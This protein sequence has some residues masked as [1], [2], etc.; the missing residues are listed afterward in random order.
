MDLAETEDMAETE[1]M[2]GTEDMT[3]TE[4]MKNDTR[5]KERGVE[6]KPL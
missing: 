4:V 1:G 5:N 2:T 3:G 6:T